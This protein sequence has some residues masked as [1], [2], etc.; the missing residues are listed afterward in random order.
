M[1]KFYLSG[2]FERGMAHT[3]SPSEENNSSETHVQL[4]PPIVYHLRKLLRQDLDC[5]VPLSN[6]GITIPADP[7]SDLNSSLEDLYPHVD[8]RRG[9]I[10]RLERLAMLHQT[11]S[12]Q[13]AQHVQQINET[14]EQIFRLLGFTLQAQGELRGKLLLVEAFAS[15]LRSVIEALKKQ[16][17]Q[18]VT[19][20]DG[21]KAIPMAIEQLPDLILLAVK[22]PG[23]DGYNICQQLKKDPTTADIPII[24]ISSIRETEAK[25]KAFEAGGVDYI[26]KPLQTEEVMARIGNHLNLRKFQLR[27]EEQNVRL[28]SEIKERQTFEEQY[29]SLFERSL[30]GIFRTTAEGTYLSAN[31]ALAHIYGYESADE[32]INSVTNIGEQLYLQPGRREGIKTY[33]QQHGEVLGAESR[34]RRKDG[35]KIWISENL[36]VVN[37]RHGQVQYY[38]GTVR[39]IT[40]QRKLQS[41]LHNQRKQTER[42]L[43]SV[44]P[45]SVAE[46]LKYANQTI[47]ESYDEV[48]V[49]FADIDNFTAF[50]S[51]IS[52]TEQVR[53][54]NVLFS[55][56]DGL[57][58]DLG[59]EKIKTIRD[60]YF[61]AGGVP[62]P[63]ADHAEAIAHMALGMQVA[64][65][66][67]QADL[68]E[69]FKIR[70]G[71]SSGSVVAGVVGSKKFT[72]D[73]WGDPVNLASRM[74][75]SCLP[76]KIQ[77]TPAS[78]RRLK[79]KF[80][81]EDRGVSEIYGIGQMTTYWLT[82]VLTGV[83]TR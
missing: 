3:S 53:L 11:I 33:L 71:M 6:E 1:P 40:E 25:V 43:Q 32:L 76:G 64:A 56:F 54:L 44:L 59:L 55:A 77:V 34:V 83:Q 20:H 31:P 17:Y 21:T 29:R 66:Q 81:F 52:P 60:V 26:E 58:E 47:A 50:S 62:E 15:E 9:V 69:S 13:G 2:Q 67:F 38:E 75:S 51:R 27:L 30:D 49:L 45:K 37:D 74:Q 24:F 28:Q 46:R 72:Y 10:E 63:K 36:R 79:D 39:D 4:S 73:L 19:A 7:L 23:I 57:A 78:Y 14:K 42:I 5:L 35:S 22:L 82:G 41:V 12:T 61:V 18:V 80:V 16:N 65:E 48:S 70:I 8:D 68:G